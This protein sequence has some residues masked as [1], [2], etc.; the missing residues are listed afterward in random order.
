MTSRLQRTLETAPDSLSSSTP[1]ARPSSK[2]TRLTRL[3]IRVSRFGRR[4]AAFRKVF[5]VD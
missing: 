5:A 2:S 3:V 1:T 4:R